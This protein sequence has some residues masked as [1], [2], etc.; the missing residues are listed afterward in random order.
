MAIKHRTIIGQEIKALNSLNP[1]P[2]ACYSLR[3]LRFPT[4][5]SVI[6]V[7]RS[8]DNTLQNI[9]TDANGDLDEAA[10]LA[11][12]GGGDGYVRQWYDQSG[13][14]RHFIQTTNGAQPLIVATGNISRQNG[15]PCLVFN[16]SRRM[17]IPSSNA[18]FKFLYNGIGFVSMVCRYGSVANPNTA[19]FSLA[20]Y[21]TGLNT[22]FA[23]WYDDRSAN[24]YNNRYWAT[25]GNATLGVQVFRTSL[26]NAVPAITQIIQIAK[27]DVTNTTPSERCVGYVDNGAPIDTNTDNNVGTTANSLDLFLG[28]RPAATLWMVGTIQEVVIWDSHPNKNQVINNINAYYKMI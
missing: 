14:G 17:S 22:G 9:G 13:G 15:K 26:D 7:R 4:S 18:A 25:A 8:S 11:F 16:G 6:Q 23:L 27:I 1:A 28:G 2:Y 20:N 19:Y 5:G 12:V 3:N 21:N 24:G 10:L